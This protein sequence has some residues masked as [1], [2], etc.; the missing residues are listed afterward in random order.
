[1]KKMVMIAVILAL[2]IMVPV[3]I[4]GCTT[5]AK[6]KPP[7]EKPKPVPDSFTTSGWLESTGE[8]EWDDQGLY[9]PLRQEFKVMIN[10][11]KIA[12]IKFTIRFEDYDE[13][14]SDTDG[15]SPPDEL[16][17]KISGGSYEGGGSG[18]T[19]FTVTYEPAANRTLTEV[20]TLPQEWVIKVDGKCYCE[21]T[22]PKTPRPSLFVLYLPDGGVAYYLTVEYKYYK[23]EE[24]P[25]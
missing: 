15:N 13:E 23:V 17:V 24:K 16:R 25:R 20:E 9:C 22:Y 5:E 14:H 8:G 12:E 4:A 1:M 2:L 21:I 6:I 19:P 10:E 3:I 11:T 18:T 7:K